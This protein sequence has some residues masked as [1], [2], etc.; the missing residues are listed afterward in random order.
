MARLVPTVPTESP[1]T[2]WTAALFNATVKAAADFV[3]GSSG[4]TGPPRFRGYQNSAQSISNGTFTSITIDTEVIDSDGGHST[5]TNTSRY[6]CQVAGTYAV[7]G[8]VC[9]P[10]NS[11]GS[12]G[13]R[14]AV[15]GSSVQGVASLIP[16]ATG[17]SCG[18][19]VATILS[20]SVGDYVEIQGYQTSGGALNTATAS[21]LAS[22]LWALWVSF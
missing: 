14:L 7:G 16:A 2:F 20:L 5:S 21:D 17:N 11:T 10:A 4:S 13:V 3:I 22:Q 12:R 9:F 19:Q 1:G 18:T 15:N 6:T 8:S